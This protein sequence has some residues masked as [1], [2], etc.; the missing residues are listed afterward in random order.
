M[1]D[2]KSETSGMT[3]WEGLIE[4]ARMALSTL[5]AGDLEG[6]AVRAEAML[7]VAVNPQRKTKQPLPEAKLAS[8]TAEHRLLGNLLLATGRNLDV[9]RLVRGYPR[10]S[11]RTGEVNSRWVR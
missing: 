4:E 5:R 6:L 8:L 7:A 9:L 2:R 3:E 11:T 1:L 10:D